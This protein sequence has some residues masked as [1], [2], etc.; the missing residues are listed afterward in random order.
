MEEQTEK[1]RSR[2]VA[3]TNAKK[4]VKN[5]ISYSS[6]SLADVSSSWYVGYAED[7]ESV[8]AIMK[9]FEQLDQFQS[10]LN[11]SIGDPRS[12]QSPAPEVGSS[13]NTERPEAGFVDDL[14]EKEENTEVQTLSKEQLEELFKRTSNFSIRSAVKQ[15]DYDDFDDEELW[16]MEFGYEDGDVEFEEDDYQIMDDEL[17]EEEM[18]TSRRPR[19]STNTGTGSRKLDREG[20]LNR[21]KFLQIQMQDRQGNFFLMKKKVSVVDPTLPTYVKIPNPIPRSW[22]KPILPYKPQ[23]PLDQRDD[24]RYFE[25]KRILDFNLKGLGNEF[26]A[27]LMDPPFLLPGEVDDGKLSVEQFNH[28]IKSTLNIP[29]LIPGGGFL[30]I[31]MEKELIPS[32]INIVENKWKFRYVENFAWIKMDWANR[33]VKQEYRYFAKSKISCLIFRK[34]GDIELRHQRNPDCEFDFIKPMLAGMKTEEKPEFIY[35]VIQTL[36]PQALYDAEKRKNG[37]GLLELWGRKDVLRSGWTTI[38][39]P[40]WAIIQMSNKRIQRTLHSY[41]TP[42]SKS[43]KQETHSHSSPALHRTKSPS[44]E[45]QPKPTNSEETRLLKLPCE[46]YRWPIIVS[47]LTSLLKPDGKIKTPKDLTAAI[48]NYAKISSFSALLHYFHEL[49]ENTD[50][51]MSD[52]VPKMVKCALKLPK[53]FVGGVI[54][55]LKCGH[56]SAITLTQEQIASLLCNAFFCTFSHMNRGKVTSSKGF[57]LINFSYLYMGDS[58]GLC[59]K[60]MEFKLNCLFSYFQRVLGQDYEM[61]ANVTIQRVAIKSFPDF[62]SKNIPILPI[63]I[64]NTGT[65]EDS[66]TLTEPLSHL[67]FANRMIGGGALSSGCVQEEILFMLNPELIVTM[68]V[69]ER[70]DENE[71]LH[72]FGT[73]RIN[74]YSGYGKNTKWE[75]EVEDPMGFD[76]FGRRLRHI[77]A[78]DAKFYRSTSFSKSSTHSTS[79]TTSS[80]PPHPKS[81]TQFSPSNILRDIHKAYCGFLP[82]KIG[83]EELCGIATGNWGCGAF[84][85]DKELKALIQLI[86]FSSARCGKLD[87]TTVADCEDL[88]ASMVLRLYS[89]N[90]SLPLTLSS[91]A[92][93]MSEGDDRLQGKKLVY[94]TFGETKFAQDLSVFSDFLVK[95]GVTVGQLLNAIFKFNPEKSESGIFDYLFTVL[96]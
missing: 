80:S 13:S 6:N 44:P 68:L 82:S 79:S 36:L 86:A 67:D 11:S 91:V 18:E 95:R 27:I 23:Q 29:A 3:A 52:V 41:F 93:F 17:W 38:V 78:I 62:A 7:E 87:D 58:E 75:G 64:A 71:C 20:L 26:Q 50:E 94:F 66:S 70:M 89:T 60:S 57:P 4:R 37:C 55:L 15:I 19:S 30:F 14:F 25:T 2:R 53:L 54:P 8:E 47:S 48:C 65:I 59:A 12:S 49:C 85:G 39:E 42:P 10:E 22:A 63:V 72:V 81:D 90:A 24:V 73:E 84:G 61:K 9:K 16:K 88:T 56:H 1:K 33:M 5:A 31:W 51:L 83:G 43:P 92:S 32:I 21:Y 76:K 96:S 46:S 40:I 34:E 77:I 74:S 28:I 69:A 45:P 35:D